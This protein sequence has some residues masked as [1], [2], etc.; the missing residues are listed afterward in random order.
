MNGI[1]PATDYKMKRKTSKL[2]CTRNKMYITGSL[3]FSNFIQSY[4]ISFQG[5]K[6]K[7]SVSFNKFHLYYFSF[8]TL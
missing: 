2:K 3:T 4:E 7:G 5:V 8:N 6:M 1:A